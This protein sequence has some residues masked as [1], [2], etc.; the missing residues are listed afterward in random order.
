MYPLFKNRKRYLFNKDEYIRSYL[1]YLANLQQAS[2]QNEMRN[3]VD[4]STPISSVKASGIVQV[5]LDYSLIILF[6]QSN[7]VKVATRERRDI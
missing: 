1:E 5:G 7:D 6:S 2:S 3:E 4:I